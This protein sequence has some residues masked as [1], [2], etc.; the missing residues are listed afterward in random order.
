MSRIAK[1]YALYKGDDYLAEGT[2]KELAKMFKMSHKS[3]M[4]TKCPSRIKRQAKQKKPSKAYML[5]DLEE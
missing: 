4:C 1:I 2:V 5:V 3:L